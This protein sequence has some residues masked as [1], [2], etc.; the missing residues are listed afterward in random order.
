M[1]L[2]G[3]DCDEKLWS[4]EVRTD[5]GCFPDCPQVSPRRCNLGQTVLL[6]HGSGGAGETLTVTL[7]SSTRSVSPAS[8]AWGF[9]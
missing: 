6:L 4:E 9:L 5:R 3:G 8:T 7:F 2:T 1:L